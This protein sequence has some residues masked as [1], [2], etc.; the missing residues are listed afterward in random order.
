MQL[1]LLPSAL[2]ILV[3]I[4]KTAPLAAHVQEIA[5]ALGISLYDD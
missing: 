5:P 1:A 3:L 2:V 4:E